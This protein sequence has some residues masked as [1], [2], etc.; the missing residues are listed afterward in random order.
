MSRLDDYRTALLAAHPDVAE[1]R[2]VAALDE[3]PNK[4]P[5]FVVDMGLGPLWHERTG[6]ADFHESRLQAEALYLAQERSLDDIGA[7]LDAAGIDHVAIKGAATRLLLYDNPAVRASFDLD[8]LVRS[9]DRLEAAETISRLGFAPLPEA[10]SISRELV[11]ARSGTDVDLH[12][13][14]LREGR[15]RKDPT[16]DILA[17]RRR[18]GSAWVPSSNDM[19]FILL[20]HPAFAKHLGGWE[21]GLHRVA[22]LLAFLGT[23]DFELPSVLALVRDNGVSAAAWATLR[24]TELLAE[25]HV[26]PNLPILLAELEPPRFKRA[27]LD[28]WLRND[29]SDRLAAFH[30]TRLVAFSW[31]LHDTPADALRAFRGR[32]RA[33]RRSGEDLAAFAGLLGE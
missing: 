4:F 12:W 19:L 13:G 10:R 7:A 16:A 9:A 23:Q 5:R 6:R 8:L 27:W 29:L 31:T 33:V 21:M 18:V 1:E 2:L 30:G 32:R 20:V 3:R 15:L 25:P 17:R 14:L 22:D 11:L 28:R 24:W 26:P